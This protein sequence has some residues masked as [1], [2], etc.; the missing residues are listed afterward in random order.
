MI[1][2]SELLGEV[3]YKP[4]MGRRVDLMTRTDALDETLTA[5]E[6][7]KLRAD[8]A[9]LQ[10]IREQAERVALFE[11]QRPQWVE[12]GQTIEARRLAMGLSMN[13]AA[14]AIGTTYNTIHGYVRARCPIH[15]K[16]YGPIREAFGVDVVGM[17][18]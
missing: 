15:P 13:A 10:R 9:R 1:T 16:F 6:L 11:Q 4:R 8:A 5:E 12:I 14:L 7:A 3:R 17:L 18:K 2:A